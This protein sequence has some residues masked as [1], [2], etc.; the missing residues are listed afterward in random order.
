MA[1][2]KGGRGGLCC[3]GCSRHSG[4]KGDKLLLAQGE[5]V[6]GHSALRV[7]L[8]EQPESR[9]QESIPSQCHLQSLMAV[10]R[11]RHP[12]ELLG[13]VGSPWPCRS[14]PFPCVTGLKAGDEVVEINQRA[15]E[16]LD[17]ALLKDALGQ[18]S[19]SLTVRTHPEAEEGQRL[20]QPPPRRPENPPEPGDS[21][22]ALPGGSQGTGLGQR[23]LLHAHCGG[24]DGSDSLGWAQG[25]CVT[26]ATTKGTSQTLT[27]TAAP[28]WA[29]QELLFPS[30]FTHRICVWQGEEELKHSVC[31]LG[32]HCIRQ[33]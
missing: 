12:S 32:H 13:C 29:A 2:G 6:P 10:S 31:S 17:S 24:R 3:V 20:G 33:V 23:S 15:A 25:P 19:L 4:R 16:E 22:L 26:C 7:A 21:A 8:Q 5:G 30:G 9:S 18:P 1:F 28:S 11:H 14:D 27:E